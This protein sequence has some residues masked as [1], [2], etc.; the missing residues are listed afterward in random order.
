MG[1]SG[2]SEGLA[3]LRW[4]GAAQA[5]YCRVMRTLLL[6]LCGILAVA[7]G[8]AAGLH[9]DLTVTLDP[10]ARRLEVEDRLR[11]P[12]G[13]HRLRLA[14]GLA[15]GEARL[16]G[17]PVAVRGNALPVTVPEGGGELQDRKSVV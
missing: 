15:V 4:R 6:A 12:G 1:R 8:W 7:P 9:H 13:T 10:A 11:L 17:K 14:P 2:I 5:L 16:D 3:C